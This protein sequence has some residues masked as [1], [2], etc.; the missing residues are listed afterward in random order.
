MSLKV[1]GIDGLAF[2]RH[3][4]LPLCSL[5]VQATN[6]FH[7][8]CSWFYDQKTPQFKRLKRMEMS[9]SKRQCCPT[10]T[11]LLFFIDSLWAMTL[12][13]VQV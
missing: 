7:S 13:F 1:T 5:V 3:L 9:G 6:C 4:F 10:E 2:V 8:L 12:F 11:Q